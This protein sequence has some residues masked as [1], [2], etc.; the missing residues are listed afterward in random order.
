LGDTTDFA[1][2]FAP[3]ALP[4]LIDADGGVETDGDREL[5][6][7]ALVGVVGVDELDVDEDEEEEDVGDFAKLGVVS[8]SVALPRLPLAAEL[9][10]VLLLI[11]LC[12][13]LVRCSF[14]DFSIE[15]YIK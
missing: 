2:D 7:I 15:S 11:M 4:L 13:P 14:P 10:V 9:L 8:R 5:F 6:D 12:S 1:E 3:F